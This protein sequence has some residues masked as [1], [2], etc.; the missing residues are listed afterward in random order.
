MPGKA[1][2]ALFVS[3]HAGA[4]V[5]AAAFAGPRPFALALVVS[6]LAGLRYLC[7]ALVSRNLGVPGIGLAVAA[8]GWLACLVALVAAIAVAGRAGAM[9]AAALPW[10]A[11]T[12]LAGPAAA[13]LIALGKGAATLFPGSKEAAA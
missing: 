2:M 13:T 8:M 4:C 11:A 7:M 3:L 6:V 9:G 1:G 5:A 12:A 10:A